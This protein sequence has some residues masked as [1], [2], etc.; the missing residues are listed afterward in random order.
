MATRSSASRR[1][2]AVSPDVFHA[3]ADPTRRRMLD[4]LR[5]GERPVHELALSFE[6]SRAAV[7]QHLRLLRDAA[8]VLERRVGRERRYRLRAGA[9]R[10]VARWL[11]KHDA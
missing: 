11:R 10:A 6:I 7:S 9:L 3:I 1:A 5:R 4:L 8:V 2:G